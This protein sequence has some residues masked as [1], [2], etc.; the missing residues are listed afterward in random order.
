MKETHYN[1]FKHLLKF[2]NY[3]VKLWIMMINQGLQKE[4]LQNLQFFI[5]KVVDSTMENIQNLRPTKL[6]HYIL[7]GYRQNLSICLSLKEWS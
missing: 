5:L 2:L 7:I 4:G 3:L 6:R 1:S